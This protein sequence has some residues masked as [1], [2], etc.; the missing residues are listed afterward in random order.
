M[1]PLLVEMV[2]RTIRYVPTDFAQDRYDRKTNLH[3]FM[4]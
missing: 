3:P 4:A 2:K 1:D